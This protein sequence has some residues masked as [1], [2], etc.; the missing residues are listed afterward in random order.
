M[1]TCARPTCARPT[2]ARLRPFPR[3]RPPGVPTYSRLATQRATYAHTGAPVCS[4]SVCRAHFCAGLGPGSACNRPRSHT[5]TTHLPAPIHQAAEGAKPHPAGGPPQLRPGHER[6]GHLLQHVLW[7]HRGGG[8]HDQGGGGG[9]HAPWP[10]PRRPLGQGGR[11]RLL[12]LLGR[13]RRGA[14]TVVWWHAAC[15]YHS[16]SVAV[17]RQAACQAPP[18]AGVCGA[19]LQI[20]CAR[21]TASAPPTPISPAHTATC[22]NLGTRLR[23]RWTL[24]T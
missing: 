20:S 8:Q 19:H 22:S 2:R 3:F 17:L 6:R 13:A 18:P 21:H 5:P 7:E 1:L 11:V 12:R 10:R 24:A 16:T 4:R 15:W 9:G 14:L 23:G